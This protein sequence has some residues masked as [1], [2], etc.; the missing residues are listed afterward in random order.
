LTGFGGVV[1]ALNG[2]AV[3]QRW[4]GLVDMTPDGLP[5]IDASSGPGGL[6]LVTGLCGHGFTLGLALGETAADLVLDS[7]TDRD[8]EAFALARFAGGR[9]PQP[10][11]MI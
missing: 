6:V 8:L 1:P 7:R 4:G 10:A 5:V 3:T 2:V 11:M 9:V